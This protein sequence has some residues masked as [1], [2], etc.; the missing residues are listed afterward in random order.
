[1]KKILV[2]LDGSTNS[3]K[4][5]RLAVELA[6]KFH[7][8]I[9]A[10]NVVS[11]AVLFHHE[12]ASSVKRSIAPLEKRGMEF[13]NKASAYGKTSGVTIEK[14]QDHGD[15]ADRI[16][17]I[18]EQERITLVVMGKR[19]LSRVKSLLI[20]SASSRVVRLARCPVLIVY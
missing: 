5:L 19:G 10:L 7:S 3:D 18:A 11:S 14:R 20:G 4:A 16:I 6:E 12:P 1:M 8:K 15:P 2:P 9:I 17:E 13:L